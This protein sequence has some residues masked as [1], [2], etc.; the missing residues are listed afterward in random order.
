[1]KKTTTA[2]MTLLIILSLLLCSCAPGLPYR[3]WESW[4]EMKE[5]LGDHYLYPT[6]LPEFT[7]TRSVILVSNY[8]YYPLIPWAIG[9][10]G[11]KQYFGYWSDYWGEY[12]SDGLS[13]DTF[14]FNACDYERVRERTDETSMSFS[15]EPFVHRYDYEVFNEITETLDGIDIMFVTKYVNPM[16]H[17][18]IATDIPMSNRRSVFID[19]KLDGISY[20]AVITQYDIEEKYADD[21]P[22]EEL[23]KVAKSIIEQTEVD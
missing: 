14:R 5:T 21:E 20:S 16:E 1:M 11:D 23:L 7:K 12:I 19:F 13:T 3:V 22:R 18:D 10:S 2:L 8:N 4:D 9:V 15:A 6:Y 17:R